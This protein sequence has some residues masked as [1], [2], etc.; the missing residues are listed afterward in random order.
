MSGV[1]SCSWQDSIETT[2]DWSICE[3][4]NYIM[5][6]VAIATVVKPNK[7]GCGVFRGTDNIIYVFWK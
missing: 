6:A 2:D 7:Q 3:G 5:C 1:C 4:K